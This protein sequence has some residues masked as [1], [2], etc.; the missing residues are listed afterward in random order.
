VNRWLFKI[1]SGGKK[2]WERRL[3]EIIGATPLIA[4]G[5]RVYIVSHWGDLRTFQQG[6]ADH[7]YFYLY[8]FGHASP[9]LGSDGT[10]Y[11]PGKYKLLYALDVR[12]ALAQSPW[13]KFRGDIRN[14]GRVNGIKP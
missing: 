11:I 14:S 12:Q 10:L 13:P 4:A 8:H 2:I 6:K 5:D 7:S 3:E 9:T 1:D